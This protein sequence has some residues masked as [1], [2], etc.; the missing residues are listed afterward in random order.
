MAN[1]QL[2][3]IHPNIGPNVL[4]SPLPPTSSST[5]TPLTGHLSTS[6]QLPQQDPE[7]HTRYQQLLNHLL[8]IKG[9]HKGGY[10]CHHC[11]V[12]NESMPSSSE[13]KEGVCVCGCSHLKAV[14][15]KVL[16]ESEILGQI[17]PNDSAATNIRR[18]ISYTDWLK[19]EYIWG[20]LI[21]FKPD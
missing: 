5:V 9:T 12:N 13:L 16:L 21:G 1:Q 14:M 6:T 4:P 19:M 15:E 18:S 3:P 2:G 7:S 17:V 10:K 8:I 20:Q 11:K